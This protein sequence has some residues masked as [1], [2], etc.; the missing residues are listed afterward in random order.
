M[1]IKEALNIDDSYTI[2]K[3]SDGVACYVQSDDSTIRKY[4]ILQSTVQQTDNEDILLKALEEWNKNHLPEETVSVAILCSIDEIFDYKVGYGVHLLFPYYK[5]YEDCFMYIKEVSS[6]FFTDGK[7]SCTL[8]L[9]P[10]RVMDEQDWD[11]T[12]NT[13]TDDNEYTTFLAN[14]IITYAKQFFGIPYVWGGTTPSGFD[15]SGLVQYV[16]NH[17]SIEDGL[18]CSLQR[19]TT[20]QCWQGKSINKDDQSKW[21]VADLIFFGVGKSDSPHHVGILSKC[22]N[23]QWYYIHA[24]QS[25][26]VVKESP[27]TRSDIHSIRRVIKEEAKQ[28]NSGVSIS[29]TNSVGLGLYTE[30][31]VSYIKVCEGFKGSSYSADGG[32]S[33]TIGYGFTYSYNKEIYNNGASNSTITEAQAD[34]YLRKLLNQVGK[35]VQDYCNKNGCILMPNVRDALIDYCYLLGF[36]SAKPILNAVISNS[37]QNTHHD[38]KQ[39]AL[40]CAS[41]YGSTYNGRIASTF[42]ILK[43][44]AYKPYNS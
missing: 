26:D 44:G 42:N 16:Y 33:W 24:P 38:I 22:E 37:T 6:K 7:F 10:S 8:T 34:V 5:Q 41:A 25:G 15:C 13:S 29:S 27:L 4:G 20:Q 18:L 1:G 30:N 3:N 32:K 12:E 35:Q 11:T 21:Q 43:N 19:V 2:A 17:F 9:T 39:V 40:N 36:G 14:R 31:L 23:G 28:S